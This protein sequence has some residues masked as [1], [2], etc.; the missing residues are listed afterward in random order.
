MF[1]FCLDMLDKKVGNPANNMDVAVIIFGLPNEQLKVLFLPKYDP[2]NSNAKIFILK[3]VQ[4][5]QTM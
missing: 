5:K 2:C 1:N 3:N 4:E